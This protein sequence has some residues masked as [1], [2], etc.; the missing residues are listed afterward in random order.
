MELPNNKTILAKANDAY[1]Q[2]EFGVSAQLY[3]AILD[4]QLNGGEIFQCHNRLAHSLLQSNDLQNAK[5]AFQE[6]TSKMPE[7][8]HGFEGLALIAVREKKYAQAIEY[9]KIVVARYNNIPHAF[10]QLAECYLKNN[11]EFEAKM[12]LKEAI[13]LYPTHTY[14]YAK[15]AKLAVSSDDFELIQYYYD[16]AK[17]HAKSDDETKQVHQDFY[18][19][20]EGWANWGKTVEKSQVIKTAKRWERVVEL[21]PNHSKAVAGLCEPLLTMGELDRVD[22]LLRVYNESNLDEN[23]DIVRIEFLLAHHSERWADAKAYFLIL[24]DNFYDKCD[25]IYIWYFFRCL[26]K[27][28]QEELILDYYIKHIQ[29]KYPKILEY[30]PN[31]DFHIEK[32]SVARYLTDKSKVSRLKQTYRPHALSHQYEYPKL[33]DEQFKVLEHNK[34]N[35]T[36]IIVFSGL[37]ENNPYTVY[38][39]T[40]LS[41]LNELI[42]HFDTEK[43]FTFKNFTHKNTQYNFLLINDIYNSWYQLNFEGYLLKIKETICQLAPKKIVCLGAS[44]GGFASLVFGQLIDA[45]LVFSFAPQGVAITA[46]SGPYT[47]DLQIQFSLGIKDYASIFDVQRLYD[48]FRSKTFLMCCKNQGADMFSIS[49]L[50]YTDKNLHY[51]EVF[52]DDHSLI[53]YLGAKNI[54]ADMCQVIDNFENFDSIAD[55]NLF[56]QNGVR[57]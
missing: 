6:M 3:K 18:E 31:H 55:N 21:Y 36:L 54:F 57:F 24:F 5:Q 9:W 53:L 33:F 35:E 4:S 12:A 41:Q 40:R 29:L 42:E 25:I 10:I 48:G 39:K 16:M 26:Q 30:Y 44:A 52:G 20:F 46:Y 13:F 28:G 8:H 17:K 15:L 47:K 1:S 14:A 56:K 50:D 34:E 22:E 45:D 37:G 51:T 2:K 32:L 43:G 49:N 19:A 11:Q 7:V 23:F 27:L 38:S